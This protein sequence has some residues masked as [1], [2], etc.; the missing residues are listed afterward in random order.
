VLAAAA[1]VL[2]LVLQLIFSWLLNRGSDPVF[3]Q[4]A[5]IR[6]AAPARLSAPAPSGP[7][8]VRVA[9]F[10]APE[11]AEGL[12]TVTETADRSTVTLRGDGVFAS[13]SAD[14]ARNFEP[15]LARIG[16][17]LKTVPGKVIVV[18]HTDNV[19]PALSARLPSNYDLSKAR[20]KTVVGLLAERSGPPERYSSEGR[21]ETEPVAPNDTPANRARNRRV[22][23]IVLT[24][25]QGR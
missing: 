19:K 17:A 18:G 13:G 10:L 25:A 5:A 15:L 20:A 14:V 9:G 7:A 6:V 11:I 3:A 1:G 21:G 4:L 16:D 2:L 8:P 23:I 12:V 22:D 24:P